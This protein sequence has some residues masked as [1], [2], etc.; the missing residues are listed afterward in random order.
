ML[1]AFWVRSFHIHD[2]GHL[3]SGTRA[4]TLDSSRGVIGVGTFPLPVHFPTRWRRWEDR[5]KFNQLPFTA[6]S[7]PATVLGFG[8]YSKEW[9][10]WYFVPYWFLTLLVV[11]LGVCSWMLGRN[12]S[13]L[14]TL[15]IT[16]LIIAVGVRLF[17]WP[18]VVSSRIY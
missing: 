6:P 4:V 3:T 14:T 9:H 8:H 12:R 1:I 2:Y 15:L 17:L 5:K 18:L 11:V 10:S 13:N 7:R 16:T